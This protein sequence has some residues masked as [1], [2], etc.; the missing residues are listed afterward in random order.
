MLPE[1]RRSTLDIAD[2]ALLVVGA[3]MV[4]LIA[5]KLIGIIVGTVFFAIKIAIIVFIIAAAFR[6]ATGRSRH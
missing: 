3:I 2:N 5:L 1:R 6:F 4:G